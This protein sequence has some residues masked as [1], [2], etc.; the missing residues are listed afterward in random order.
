M[1]GIDIESEFIQKDNIDKVWNYIKNINVDIAKIF[2]LH[3]ILD[4]T[5][6]EISQ[7]LDI[8]ESSIKSSLYR[9]LLK[10]KKNYYGGE[11]NE[12]QK[13]ITKIL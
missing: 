6:K 13:G 1:L 12:K 8:N 11:I 9:M 2:Y 10:V 7:K 3:F 4:M 5:F